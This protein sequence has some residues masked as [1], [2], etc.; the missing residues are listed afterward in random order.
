MT[1]YFDYDDQAVEYLKKNERKPFCTPGSKRYSPTVLHT[2][3]R[4]IFF[5]SPIKS[6]TGV[7]IPGLTDPV[8][9]GRSKK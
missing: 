2:G 8:A 6:A 4:D 5:P 1:E 3:R 7:L 9:A